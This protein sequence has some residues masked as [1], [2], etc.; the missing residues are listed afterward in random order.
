[1]QLDIEGDGESRMVR[2]RRL[3]ARLERAY[4]TA[5]RVMLLL[6][7]TAAMLYAAWLVAS[8]VYRL[9]RDASRVKEEP[10]VVAAA[11]V[12]ALPAASESEKDAAP[13]DPWRTQKAYYRSFVDRYFALWRQKYAPFQQNADPKFDRPAFDTRYVRSSARIEAVSNGDLDFAKD[14]AALDRL[15]TVMQ[16]VTALP[17]TH[18]RLKR[19]RAAVRTR[20]TRTVGGTRSERYCSYYGYYVQECLVYDTRQVPYSKTVTEL[21]LPKGVVDPRD[22]FGRYQDR[23]FSLFEERTGD[24]V[25]KAEQARAKIV[26]GNAEGSISMWRAVQFA[27]GFLLIMFLFLLIAIERHQRKLAGALEDGQQ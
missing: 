4:L 7:A 5:L 8:G 16:E 25:R 11:E 27:A 18:Q 24:S 17:E 12:A 6:L 13:A 1:M 3:I 14:K 9:S 23:F 19:Y 10:V 20:T 15:L 26:A 22:L 2:V 21:R